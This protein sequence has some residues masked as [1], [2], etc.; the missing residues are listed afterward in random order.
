[1]TIALLSN[2]HSSH[3]TSALT[4]SPTV[5]RNN[6]NLRASSKHSLSVTSFQ[7]W[8][9]I[10]GCCHDSAHGCR[11]VYL[12]HSC[13]VRHRIIRTW[14]KPLSSIIISQ[15]RISSE[16]WAA[17]DSDYET[18]SSSSSIRTTLEPEEIAKLPLSDILQ[19]LNEQ[20][21]RYAPDA[22]RVQLEKLLSQYVVVGEVASTTNKSTSRESS[23]LERKRQ[24]NNFDDVRSEREDKE[25]K[26]V[27]VSR[28]SD[29]DGG[30][31][32]DLDEIILRD[33]DPSFRETS[34]RIYDSNDDSQQFANHE[35]YVNYGKVPRQENAGQFSPPMDAYYSSPG[36]RR[37]RKSRRRATRRQYP[38][39][40][41]DE[42][43]YWDR[44][45]YQQ[46]RQNRY[47][48]ET[49]SRSRNDYD[50]YND[51]YD[52]DKYH[53][54]EGDGNVID[55]E[56]FKLSDNPNDEDNRRKP[57][58][59]NGMQIF[60]M[61]FYEAGKTAT[62][63]AV[64]AVADSIQI[65]FS[66]YREGRGE[67]E[68]YYDESLGRDILDVNILAESKENRGRRKDYVAGDG[69]RF[70][71]EP[72]RPY[73]RRHGP[74]YSTTMPRS[75][76][77][78]YDEEEEMKYHNKVPSRTIEERY[79]R[80]R[81]PRSKVRSETNEDGS[82]KSSYG[83]YRG[84]EDESA[85]NVMDE[86]LPIDSQQ[87]QQPSQN[88]NKHQKRY[89]KD[90]VRHK[91][92]VALGLDTAASSNSESYYDNWKSRLEQMDDG[93]KEIL[94]NKLNVMENFT[95]LS[96]AKM[97]DM[98]SRDQKSYPNNRRAR[99]RARILSK[100]SESQQRTPVKTPSKSR[101]EEVPFWREGGSLASL[102][103]DTQY[104]SDNSSGNGTRNKRRIPKKNSLERLILS[105][106]GRDHT[107]TS[108]VLY[109][110][111]MVLSSF[112]ILCRWAGVRGT[113]PQSIVVISVFASIVSARRGQRI[114]A[115]LISLLGLRMVGE[116]IHGSLYGNEFW[117]D[118]YDSVAQAWGKDRKSS[119]GAD[120]GSLK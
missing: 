9:H 64:D 20:N 71:R 80:P 88:R 104:K 43:S 2:H 41:Y 22:T 59:E 55:L 82:P 40:N 85:A 100:T 62:Q 18:D 97:P 79:S 115:L 8:S 92:D 101:T 90:R 103:F 27:S 12:D 24:R 108:L 10:P 113:I 30:S 66:N 72:S 84:T 119:D 31:D 51:Y 58:Y 68:W 102:L 26:D 5:P 63:L 23:P 36:G 38:N 76:R 120:Y 21:V 110:T 32:D 116:F 118:E 117:D 52:T 56:T 1:M 16:L 46:W 114:I 106:R 15:R 105:P 69:E 96:A 47:R 112:G 7:T 60:L 73:R 44:R 34:S 83:L 87:D 91:F 33:D 67:G 78:Y 49:N 65:P 35:S 17:T 107:V 42:D 25:D 6:N 29:L 86:V 111:R 81:R 99:R 45:K 14:A 19:K 57:L 77:R 75:R 39:D 89:W 50:M 61:G 54:N 48:G 94:R 95:D 28:L 13:C 109:S 3:L 70:Y 74:E 37:R 93:R 4:A 53:V 11:A 98:Q